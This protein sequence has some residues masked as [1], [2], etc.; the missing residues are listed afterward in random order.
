MFSFTFLAPTYRLPHRFSFVSSIDSGEITV[1]DM[2]KLYRFEN[3]LYTMKL[4]GKEIDGF[5]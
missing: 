4:T 3:F 5:S 1:S 2:F